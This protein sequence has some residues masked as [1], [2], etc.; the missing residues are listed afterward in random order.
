MGYGHEY[1]ETL[2][3]GILI[4]SKVSGDGGGTLGCF[5][6]K[7]T[8]PSK[9]VLLSNSHV[10][11]GDVQSM[12][13]SPDAGNGALIGQPNVSCCWCCVCRDIAKNVS[14]G[15]DLVSV[16]ISNPPQGF[17]PNQEGSRYDAAIAEWNSERP[18]TNQAEYGMITG[19]ITSGLGVTA[20]APV[21]MVGSTSGH[22]SGSVL[23]FMTQW[24]SGASPHSNLL[25]P[26]AIGGG[27]IDDDFAGAK[28]PSVLQFLILPNA[29]PND[30]NRAM[31]FGRRGDS[32]S[33]VVNGDRKV[34]GLVSRVIVITDDTRPI[35]NRF[36]STPLPPHAGTLAVVAPIAPVL[37]RFDI[38]IV[39]NMSG[40]V[41]SGGSPAE[42]TRLLD[43]RQLHA[44]R[45][46][47]LTELRDEIGASRL[48]RRIIEIVDR[49]AEEITRLV[50]TNRQVKVAWNRNKGPAFAA[51]CLHSFDDRDYRVPEA[52]DGVSRNELLIRMG[53][54]LVRNGSLE[55][56]KDIEKH[57]K[58]L[59]EVIE[60]AQSVWDLLERFRRLEADSALVE[61][62]A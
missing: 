53:A 55:L 6:R 59:L 14:N 49:H 44:Q 43:R 8:D 38:E 58:R 27:S 57:G 20:G 48:G 16:T 60:G 56:V 33:V 1:Q 45:E 22:I 29:D 40:T 50:N 54:A 52:V 36:L 34:I 9:I 11:Y 39:N 42:I 2:K 24:T 32:G 62:L 10:L 17:G 37:Q 30:S 7:K 18:Y 41:P 13:A 47:E 12:S 5:A 23:G 31:Y 28:I 3:P 21:E 35:V 19:A 4:T 15:F 46:A 25:F 26:P 61:E 51:H